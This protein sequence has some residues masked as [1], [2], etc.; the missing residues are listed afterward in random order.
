MPGAITYVLIGSRIGGVSYSK[1]VQQ[2]FTEAAILA[3]TEFS[4]LSC[5]SYIG[6]R[7]ERRIPQLPSWVPDYTIP[8][9]VKPLASSDR[10][11]AATTWQTQAEISGSVPQTLT[12]EGAY[13]DD[14]VGVCT[15]YWNANEPNGISNLLNLA[16][17]PIPFS[18][19][20]DLSF[21]DQ[22]RTT[23][24]AELYTRRDQIEP[25]AGSQELEDSFQRWMF[26]QSYSAL[27]RQDIHLANSFLLEPKTTFESAMHALGISGPLNLLT[28]SL[29]GQFR[30]DVWTTLTLISNQAS[31]EQLFSVFS[32]AFEGDIFTNDWTDFCANR[33]VFRTEKGYLGLGPSWMKSGDRVYIV[34]G[35][36]VP[37]VFR[38]L[39]AKGETAFELEGDVYIRGIMEGEAEERLGR[40]L[41]WSEI[42]VH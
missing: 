19:D 12:L 33:S 36:A 3:L 9:I 37:Y 23:L 6:P 2:V 31:Q 40:P 39:P 28:G 30:D 15:A 27:A 17:N 20:P 16:M 1:P 32:N 26:R 34:K 10:F 7:D 18:L 41:Y 38:P 8:L 42:V 29:T 35:A 4:N 11:S 24:H 25:E 13:I 22:L 21:M 5:L 14:V